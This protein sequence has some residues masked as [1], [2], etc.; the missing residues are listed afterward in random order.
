MQTGKDRELGGGHLGNRCGEDRKMALRDPAQEVADL[1]IETIFFRTIHLN[2]IRAEIA[3]CKTVDRAQG[4]S[5][6]VFMQTNL[7]D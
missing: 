6:S 7:R 4:G 1:V 2:A 3:Q 5:Q